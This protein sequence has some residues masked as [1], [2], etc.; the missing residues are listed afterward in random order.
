M[1]NKFISFTFFAFLASLAFFADAAFA[2]SSTV[3]TSGA[4]F[5][6]LGAG[7]RP[8]AMGGAFTAVADDVNALAWNPAGL[9]GMK[10][11]ELMASYALWFSDLRYSYAAYVHP[12]DQ[13]AL[14]VQVAMLGMGSFAGYTVDGSGNPVESDS[15][16]ASDFSAAL[17]YGL[18]IFKDKQQDFM[19]GATAKFISSTIADVGATAFGGDFGVLWRLQKGNVMLGAAVRHLG[20]SMK[21]SSTTV[22]LPMVV[23]FGLGVKG[24]KEITFSGDVEIPS[25]QSMR[26][27]G[28][29]EWVIENTIAVRG[30]YALR[31]DGSE[32]TG[33]LMGWTAGIGF[34]QDSFRLDYSFVPYGTLGN[35]HRVSLGM[36]FGSDGNTSSSQDRPEMNDRVEKTVKRKDGEKSVVAVLNFEAQRGVSPTHV[37]MAR[38][39]MGHEFTQMGHFSMVDR[40]VLDAVMKKLAFQ[41]GE[42]ASVECAVEIG[43]RV[44]AEYVLVGNVKKIGKDFVLT[45]QVVDVASGKMTASGSEEYS[46]EEFVKIAVKGVARK[47]A[48]EF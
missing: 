25:D 41:N 1:F 18:T 34:R 28:G 37:E 31:T 2:A 43:K 26:V 12:L 42:C 11:G 45:G 36:N 47:L 39:Y 27:G 48:A 32:Y 38:T 24:S 30:G 4:S 9:G 15:F 13:Q 22:N 8:A 35:T 44:R 21:F 16:S 17:S 7:A 29:V 14:G 10:R 3:G 40:V 23:A 19:I 46:R 6:K 20:T 5:L 33:A